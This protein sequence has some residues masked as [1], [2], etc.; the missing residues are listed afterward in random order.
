MSI[1]VL[2]LLTIAAFSKTNTDAYLPTYG[3]RAQPL[4]Q[5]DVSNLKDF[6]TRV[7]VTLRRARPDAP[8][9]AVIGTPP[10]G[11]PAREETMIPY[12]QHEGAATALEW[13]ALVF[14]FFGLFVLWW[15]RDPASLWLGVFNA[16]FAP[17]IFD[18]YTAVPEWA[19]LLATLVSQSL[20]YLSFYAFF[21][22][23][24]TFALEALAEGSPIRA[25]IGSVRDFAI[26]A[27]VVAGTINTA[28]K[29][30]PTVLA[31]SVW[32]WVSA[33]GTVAY[34]IAIVGVFGLAPI[35][36]LLA[37]WLWAKNPAAK[38]KVRVILLTTVAAESGFFVSTCPHLLS[39]F[40]HG[41]RAEHIGFDNAW[42]TLLAIPLGFLFTIPAYKTVEVKFVI[43]RILVLTTMTIVI[44]AIITYTETW[45]D[46]TFHD[47]MSDAMV[48]WLSGLTGAEPKTL[49]R[50]LQFLVAFTIVLSFSRFHEA[51][52]EFFK[53]LFFK[54]RDGAIKMLSDFARSRAQFITDREEMMQQ[55]V[56]LVCGA[57]GARGS[58]FY[59]AGGGNYQLSSACGDADWP[60]MLSENDPAFAVMRGG[61]E[62]V[63]LRELDPTPSAL[64]LE[65]VCVRMAMC[66]RVI[67]AL[68]VGARV[69]EGDGPYEDAELDVL[70]ELARSVSDVLFNI[71]A[72]EAAKFVRRVADG[73]IPGSQA[74]QQA[75][76]LRAEGLADIDA[77]IARPNALKAPPVVSLA[78]K[79]IETSAA[80][81]I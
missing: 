3:D 75:E 58:A 10:D 43:N 78:T 12:R 49:A 27:L 42:Y 72:S 61:R 17:W 25:R 51:L 48:T 34:D 65:G 55:A 1:V 81:H 8:H 33:L 7:D 52:D 26:A 20:V 21:E 79:R 41:I 32:G 23:A 5:V 6:P 63:D 16:S 70:H 13:S 44:G 71:R 45:V 77:P 11:G 69:R 62:R 36:I 76:L 30:G 53:A 40:Q 56:A 60:S 2:T 28:E 29:L 64:G 54:R 50:V 31:E 37:A 47:P 9:Q 4:D 22:I 14:A 73:T 46:R 67:G 74:M 66:N 19:M 38:S 24:H 80:E 57:V 59:E 68:V 15:G 39:T 18:L 35:A